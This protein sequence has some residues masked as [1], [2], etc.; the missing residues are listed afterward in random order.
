VAP[1]GL[2]VY[3]ASANGGVLRSD[4]GGVSWTSLMDGFDLAPTEFASTSLACG[5][6]AIDLN[7]PKRVYMGTGEGDT[8]AIFKN[9]ILN[10]L[11]AYRG[12][13]PI[14]SDDGGVTWQSEPAAADSTDLAGKAFFALAVDLWLAN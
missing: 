14:R 7:D 3:V 13:G 9:R 5:A 2:T 10:A 11:P 8:Y 1:G 4:D 12:V 6:I